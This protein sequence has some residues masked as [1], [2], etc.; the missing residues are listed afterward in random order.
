[1]ADLPA[2]VLTGGGSADRL[3]Q[4]C[5]R[6]RGFRPWSNRRAQPSP[7][8]VEGMYEGAIDVRRPQAAGLALGSAAPRAWGRPSCDLSR[9][10]AAIWTFAHPAQRYLTRGAQ[11]R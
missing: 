6:R 4:K 1:M 8:G 9:P 3:G 11:G 7:E 10:L 2:L 5:Y